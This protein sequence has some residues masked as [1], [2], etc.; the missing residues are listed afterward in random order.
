MLIAE[1]LI[2]LFSNKY[3][4]HFLLRYTL[5]DYIDDIIRIAKR[6]KHNDDIRFIIITLFRNLLTI[7]YQEYF[8]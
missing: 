1:K 3:I 7:V 5:Y 8:N 6:F 4:Y 2:T